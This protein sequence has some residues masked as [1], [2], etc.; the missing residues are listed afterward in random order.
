MKAIRAQ[1]AAQQTPTHPAFPFKAAE[2]S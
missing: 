1:I 2:Q